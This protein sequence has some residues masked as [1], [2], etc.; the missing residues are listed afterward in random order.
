MMRALGQPEFEVTSDVAA[1]SE[2]EPLSFTAEV[3]IRPEISVP[4]LDAIP[5]TVDD[6]DVTDD[7]IGQELDAL[8]ER[9][10][11]LKGVDRAAQDGDYVSLDL[12]ATA[13][14]EEIEGLAQRNVSHKVGSGDLIDG[15]DEAVVGTE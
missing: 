15:L 6:V 10:G 9:F 12:T 11:T 4:E 3:D 2:S 14:G 7:E 13:G 8:R 5:I 1:L